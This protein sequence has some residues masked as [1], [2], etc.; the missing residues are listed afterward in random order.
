LGWRDPRRRHRNSWGCLRALLAAYAL[1][2][3]PLGSSSRVESPTMTR[4][5]RI[6]PSDD[7]AISLGLLERQPVRKNPLSS[8]LLLV[9]GATLGANVFDLPLAGY[10]LMAEMALAGRSVYAIDIRGFGNSRVDASEA[11]RNA[12][13]SFPSITEV[14]ADVSA[15]AT[16]ILSREWIDA[17]DLIGFSWGCIAA[18]RY[19]IQFPERVA[20]LALYAPLYGEFN[21]PWL[22]L[23]ADPTDRTRLRSDLGPYRSIALADLINRWDMEIGVPDIGAYRESGVAECVFETL[24]KL[25]P[26]VRANAIAA[27]RCPS[28]PLVDLV[29]VFNGQRPY[30][31]HDLTVPTLVVRGDDDRTSTDS[32]A[33]ALLSEIRSRDKLYAVVPCASHFLLLEKSRKAFYRALD[34]Y[35]KPMKNR[36]RVVHEGIL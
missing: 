2:T 12:L 1:G 6:P 3:L 13:G 21:R 15:A 35:F 27:F 11:Q 33:R 5:I 9:H 34:E 36:P 24:W 14:V 7:A 32:D 30:D 16:A 10:S 28:G 18:A 29:N 31:A 22:D 25:D 23:I 26:Y 20:R 4:L 8:P 17:L 19:A